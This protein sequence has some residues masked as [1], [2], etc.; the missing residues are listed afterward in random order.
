MGYLLY[1]EVLAFAP[2]DWTPAEMVV[3]LVIADDARDETRVSTLP[4]AELC[5][6]AR[7][8]PDSVR[9]VLQRLARSGY[10]FRVGHGPG[11][12]GREVRAARGHATDFRVPDFA[13]LPLIPP[14]APVDNW[15]RDGPEP[16]SAGRLYGGKAAPGGRKG[17]PRRPPLSLSTPDNP[18]P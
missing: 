11:R 12:D 5:R 2:A 9:H 6:R 14:P 16:A 3:A 10:E 18:F 8:R 4:R 1:R 7:L 13:M 15:R 17:G